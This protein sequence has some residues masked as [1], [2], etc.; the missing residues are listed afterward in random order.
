MKKYNLT[1]YFVWAW[2][3]DSHIKGRTQIEGVWEQ[4]A[5]CLGEYLDVKGM[6]VTGQWQGAEIAA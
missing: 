4:C 5:Y 6:T 1:C 3:L 2:N